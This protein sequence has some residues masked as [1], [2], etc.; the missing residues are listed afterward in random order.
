M[1]LD[2]THLAQRK[3]HFA[4]V[5]EVD[6]MLIDEARPPLI[7]SGPPPKADQQE[8]DA[9]KPKVQLPVNA[10]KAAITEF[11]TLGTKKLQPASRSPSREDGQ[12]GAPAL[13]RSFRGLP[14]NNALVQIP[15]DRYGGNSTMLVAQ[16]PIS[17]WHDTIGE[18]TPADAMLGRITTGAHRTEKR[19][20]TSEKNIKN[21]G[22]D[23]NPKHAD[24]NPEVRWVSSSEIIYPIW[25]Y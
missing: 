23:T 25:R 22:Y 7:I 16:W 2:A 3:H 1:A 9:L 19:R 20:I 10:R 14:K 11:L 5:D 15:E 6:S 24:K 21:P 13:L 4:I 8:F 17:Q 18:P 12:E